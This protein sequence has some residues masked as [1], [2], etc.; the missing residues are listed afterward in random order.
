MARRMNIMRGYMDEKFGYGATKIVDEVAKIAFG[1]MTIKVS[2][3][4]KNVR[5]RQGKDAIYDPELNDSPEDIAITPSIRE[6]LDALA[7][8]MQYQVGKPQQ[9]VDMNINHT[10]TKQID[11]SRLSLS[12]LEAYQATLEKLGLQEEEEPIE[13]EFKVLPAP[14]DK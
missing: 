7:L 4:L 12:E 5:K 6:R 11:L 13:G 8:L 14:G 3:S 10:E 9:S 2:R 1:E